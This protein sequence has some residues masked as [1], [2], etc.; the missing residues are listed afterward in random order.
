MFWEIG[1][2]LHGPFQMKI[3]SVQKAN[4]FFG[5]EPPSLWNYVRNASGGSL[6]E[7][8]RVCQWRFLV[9][10]IFPAHFGI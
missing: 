5:H 4:R 7:L 3:P 1:Q 8:D 10:G 9:S 2:V 6:V